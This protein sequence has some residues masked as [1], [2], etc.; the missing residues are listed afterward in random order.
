MAE[1]VATLGGAMITV[2]IREAKKRLSEYLRKVRA[3]ERVLITERGKPIAVITKPR[4]AVDER[5]EAMIR[6][7]EASWGGGKPKGRKN[8]R[9]L[10][11]H[12]FPMRSSRIAGEAVSRY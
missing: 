7:G 4:G 12:R 6:N 3:G 11:D 2:G 10:R 9:R 1:H 8:R 5:L